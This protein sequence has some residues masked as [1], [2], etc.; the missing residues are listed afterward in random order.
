MYVKD[1]PEQ[2]NRAWD[3]VTDATTA[4]IN[5]PMQKIVVGDFEPTRAALESFRNCIVS[6]EKPVADSTDG[7]EISR[8]V[9]LSLD[10][11]DNQSVETF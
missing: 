11:M 10:S 6:G 9:Q 5:Q 4:L 7:L 2:A 3:A 8:M 1:K